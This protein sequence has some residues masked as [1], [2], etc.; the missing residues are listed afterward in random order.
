MQ[1]EEEYQE[2]CPYIERLGVCLEP[3]ACFLRHQ[4]LNL[5]AKEFI[6]GQSVPKGVPKKEKKP[7]GLNIGGKEFKIT[8]TF[9]EGGEYAGTIHYVEQCKD[10][11]CCKGEINNCSGEACKHLGICY[12]T[13]VDEEEY[14]A[15]ES[16]GQ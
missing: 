11:K 12:C 8:S 5:K 4:T 16:K 10:C 7:E 9:D 3:E 6:P 14:G 2:C 13:L 1:V 15:E